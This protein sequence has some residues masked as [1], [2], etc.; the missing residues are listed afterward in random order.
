[1]PELS[2]YDE[3]NLL[4]SISR[5]D[6]NAFRKLLE[7]YHYI[8]FRTA[9][10]LLNDNSLAEDI[11]QEAFLKVWLHRLTLTEID[12]FGAWLRTIT[13]NII[14][15][16]LR[17]SKLQESHTGK[18]YQDLHLYP[19][20]IKPGI[21]EETYFDELIAEAVSRLPPKQKE[22][23][24]LIKKQGYTREEAAAMMQVSVETIKTHLERAMK[25]I[26][27]YCISKMD[28]ASVAVAILTLLF[29]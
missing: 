1:M 8:P 2:S 24:V 17:K 9:V 7:S 28:A 11:V 18:W 23:F 4:S 25:S 27:V 5:G 14:Y 19:L 26:R 13:T 16:Y 12:S 22:V 21:N 29:K 10:K 3:K 15:D 20:A 6:P